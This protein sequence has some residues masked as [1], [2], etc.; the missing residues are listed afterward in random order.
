MT[1]ASFRMTGKVALIT[2][3]SRGIGRAIAE[4]FADAGAR[5]VVSS[6]DQD[7][8]DRVV[9]AMRSRG[10]EAVAIACNVSRRE[11]V[12][13]LVAD[14]VERL[15]PID[16]LVG[17][18]A[19]NPYFGPLLGIE[20]RA[21]DK[22]MGT[23]VRSNLWLC[24]RVIPGMAERGGGAVILVSSIA[25]FKGD[26][27][28]GAYAVSK[29]AELQLVRSLAVEWGPSGVRVNAIAPGLVRTEFARALWEDDARRAARERVTPLRR[30]GEPEDVAG[31]VLGLADP[32]KRSDPFARRPARVVLPQRASE[33]RPHQPGRDG[34]DANPG[35]TPLH[36]K[37]PHELELRRLRH[38]VGAERRIAL[39]RRDAG[40]EDDGASAALRHAR[41]HPVAQPQIAAHVRAHHLV[42]GPVLDA[43]QRSEVGVGGGVAHEDV[44]GPQ[45][46]DGIRD[47]SVD[48]LA[49]RDVARDGDRFGTARAHG[50]HHPV[51]GVLIAARD[52]HPRPG[53]GERL[54]DRPSDAA[55]R[56]G[57]QG[58]LSSHAER[59]GRHARSLHPVSAHTRTRSRFDSA[60][61]EEALPSSPRRYTP[62]RMAASR[63][64]ENA[65]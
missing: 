27:A 7:T 43:E 26:A 31:N 47:E 54:G 60:S 65:R 22:V 46:F 44:D 30:I 61:R 28:L 2:G 45:P 32:A 42:P 20:D 15:G 23:N 49:A 40:H 38:R 55:A 33:L 57:D 58:D 63:K 56:P 3:S 11:A 39:E 14:A 13:A 36:R 19:A 62:W 12:D 10:A 6:R 29:A 9:R 59:C 1:P 16:V 35:R 51:A 17:N 48:C 52:D 18:A 25:A 5:V 24:N 8:C 21:W 37:A 53:V 4:A 50:P 34:V 64:N 41:N